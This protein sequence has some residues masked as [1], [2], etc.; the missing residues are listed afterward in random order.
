MCI[1]TPVQIIESRLSGEALRM[2]N[3]LKLRYRLAANQEITF[4]Q[5]VLRQTDVP[6]TNE[7]VLG[8]KAKFDYAPQ[9]RWLN[10][11]SYRDDRLDSVL[12]D[13]LQLTLSHNLQKEGEHIIE[14][15][16]PRVV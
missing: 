15:A 13:G 8:S 3:N 10:A 5:Q 16:T 6:K 12:A 4:L 1:A 14:R 11:L 7:V 9:L 2:Q